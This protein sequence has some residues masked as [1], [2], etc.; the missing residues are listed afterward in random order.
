MKYAIICAIFAIFGWNIFLIQR[1]QKLFKAYDAC[2][3]F[4]YHP[5]CPYKK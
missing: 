3:Q 4:T 2:T 1:D 5:D